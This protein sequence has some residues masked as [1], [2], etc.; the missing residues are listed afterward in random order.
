MHA[1]L[2]G[3]HR[4]ALIGRAGQVEDRI[5]L[6]V[7]WKRHVVPDRLEHRVGQQMGN[8]LAAAGE[9]VVRTH[10]FRARGEQPFTQV[11]A[12]EACAAGDEDAAVFVVSVK[13][14]HDSRVWASSG[15][16]A[17]RP[18]TEAVEVV[19]ATAKFANSIVRKEVL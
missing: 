6:D 10:H 9:V 3:L 8:V 18:V 7:E 17:S 1:G 5:D 12:D 14:H 15:R 16:P 4:I 2:G 19:S 13:R 11:R